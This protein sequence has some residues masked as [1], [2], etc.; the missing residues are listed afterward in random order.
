MPHHF[1]SKVWL[2]RISDE[3]RFFR[4]EVSSSEKWG[5][6]AKGNCQCDVFH[7]EFSL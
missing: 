6:V 7:S 2:K 3:F 4:D 5:K 1:Y